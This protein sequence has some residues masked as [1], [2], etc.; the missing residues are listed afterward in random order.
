[1]QLDLERVERSS[2]IAKVGLSLVCVAFVCGKSFA[3]VARLC[4][5]SSG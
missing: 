3:D 4:G 2:R 1:M 5:K